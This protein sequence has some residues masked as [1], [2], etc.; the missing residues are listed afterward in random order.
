[1][2]SFPPQLGQ[3]RDN[4]PSLTIFDDTEC[5]NKGG[6]GYLVYLSQEGLGPALHCPGRGLV[7]ANLL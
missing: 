7:P 2:G 5:G 1:M 4:L 6:E 3:W